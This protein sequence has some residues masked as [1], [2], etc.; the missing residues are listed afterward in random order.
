MKK[1][2]SEA[3]LSLSNE[4]FQ[5]LMWIPEGPQAVDS[6]VFE[7]VFLNSSSP[8]FHSNASNFLPSLLVGAV[9][10]EVT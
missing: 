8:Y 3:I 2:C 5:W 1:A 6:R 10:E 9:G 4:A 7:N